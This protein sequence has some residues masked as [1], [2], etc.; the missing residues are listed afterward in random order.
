MTKLM[1]RISAMVIEIGRHDGN[2][3]ERIE[4]NYY[5]YCINLINNKIFLLRTFR[6]E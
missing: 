4:I 2:E 6:H 1:K 3:S 5:Q